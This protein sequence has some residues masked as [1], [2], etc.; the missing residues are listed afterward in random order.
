MAREALNQWTAQSVQWRDEEKSNTN[1]EKRKIYK[2]VIHFFFVWY[3]TVR[4]GTSAVRDA[5]AVAVA[6]GRKNE[7]RSL[8]VCKLIWMHITLKTRCT[9]FAT[10]V[11]ATQAHISWHTIIKKLTDKLR[12]PHIS[13]FVFAVVYCCRCC[14]SL[15]SPLFFLRFSRLFFNLLLL[16]FNIVRGG[17]NYEVET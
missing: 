6:S 15:F 11:K 16:W 10:R 2:I 9:H 5:I 13:L 17:K 8:S 1:R 14:C 3:E 7:T 12:A 4:L